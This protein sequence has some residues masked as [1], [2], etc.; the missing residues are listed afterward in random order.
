MTTGAYGG[1]R[2]MR[3]LNDDIMA[4]ILARLP[5]VSFAAAACVNKT[6]NRLSSQILS[7]PK[8]ASALSLNPS[9]I[10]AVREVLDNVLS[11][12]IRPHFAI[13]FISEKY[14]LRLAHM[15]INDRLKNR[16]PLVVHI[17]HGVMGKDVL[18]DEL[19]EVKWEYFDYSGDHPRECNV[20]GNINKGVVLVLGFVPG[21]KVDAIPL[22]RPRQD[23]GGEQA[24]RFLADIK[25]FT[26]AASGHESP[27][28]IMMFGDRRS[29]M[30][31]VV[32]KMD[33]ALPKETVMIGDAG[34]C[35][36]F[37][38]MNHTITTPNSYVLDAVALVFAE[39]KDK[40]PD[41]GETEFN[42]VLAE[43]L[44]PFGPP[45]EVIVV[46]MNPSQE[47]TVF[48]AR[49]EGCDVILSSDAVFETVLDT[50]SDPNFELYIGVTQR[51]GEEE[52]LFFYRVLSGEGIHFVVDGIG[53]KPGDS[54]V[55]Y[56]TDKDGAVT[57]RDIA[58]ENLETLK[59]IGDENESDVFGGLIFASKFRGKAY[60]G[61]ENGDV[62]PLSENFPGVAI[63]GSFCDGEI[64]RGWCSFVTET[65]AE[66]EEDEETS[67]R[68][69]LRAF[70]ALYL[71]MSYV[72]ASA[73]IHR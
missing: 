33:H 72:T 57:S 24:D 44:V 49:M 7:R 69:S 40:S 47:W 19:R 53:L 62:M 5:A 14:G 32:A 8:L 22:F 61:E 30:N 16:V 51:R 63:A 3:R 10:H 28:A 50:V 64:G 48:S 26:A 70:S 23:P 39:D 6:W 34:G 25:A 2:T 65:E 56:H 4:N 36:L 15:L 18:S 54:F 17:S 45:F 9:L 31:S 21:L 59:E 68:C 46:G 13:A 67:G 20:Y 38:S 27:A 52:S 55:F 42:V 41:V 1:G 71:A 35:F 12:P 73:A 29:N 58:C 11:K 60:F 43:G 37:N 66:E